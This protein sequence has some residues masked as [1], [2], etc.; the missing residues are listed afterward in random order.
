[1]YKSENSPLLVKSKAFAN[2][3]MKMTRHLY[4]EH[5]VFY[6]SNYNQVNRSG[7]SVMAN[8]SES[9]FAQS[10][11]DFI[12]KLH[13]ALKEANETLSWLQV[14]KENQCLTDQEY[15]S[16]EQ[17]CRELIAMLMSSI[18]TVKKNNNL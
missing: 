18:N 3:I 12:T 14:L 2:R 11:Q 13:I 17:D 8:I 6:R 15:N 16:I 5:P 9:Q 1:M 7:T 4:D 10:P